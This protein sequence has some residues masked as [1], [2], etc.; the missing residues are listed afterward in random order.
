MCLAI[1]AKI[2]RIEK[3]MAEVDINGVKRKADVRLIENL[4]I[5][6]YILIHAGFAIEKIDPKEAGKTI[7]LLK[8][9]NEIRR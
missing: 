5:G 9:I 7:K 3:N 2:T 6:D 4:R 1:P 8:E